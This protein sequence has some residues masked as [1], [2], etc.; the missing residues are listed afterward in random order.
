MIPATN[1]QIFS[2]EN[3]DMMDQKEIISFEPFS[4]S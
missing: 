4:N 2:A 1:Q 3:P